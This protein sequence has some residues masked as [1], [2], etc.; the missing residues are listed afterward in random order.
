MMMYRRSSLK[1]TAYSVNEG[2]ATT[3]TATLNVPAIFPVQVDY[4]TQD[5]SAMAGSDYTVEAGTLL[6]AAG[7]TTKSFGV[8][9]LDDLIYEGDE[10]LALLLS[11][12]VSA[13]IGVPS[14]ATLTIFG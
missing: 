4:I 7:K 13:T 10:M 1:V 8:G 14:T 9:T 12:P 2:E 11:N 3:I 6:F 5:T